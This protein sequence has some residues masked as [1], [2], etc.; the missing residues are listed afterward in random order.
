MGELEGEGE[1]EGGMERERGRERGRT[2]RKKNWKRLHTEERK[3]E[4]EEHG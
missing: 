4:E 3:R 2:I 1:G